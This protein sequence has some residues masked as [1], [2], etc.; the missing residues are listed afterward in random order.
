MKDTSATVEIDEG[1]DRAFA[2]LP[3]MPVTANDVQACSDLCRLEVKCK[4]FAFDTCGTRCWLKGDVPYP[5]GAGC[6]VSLQLTSYAYTINFYYICT[7]LGC[8]S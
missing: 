4:S 1:Y 8:A 7:D 2:D 3:N 6:R 5:T